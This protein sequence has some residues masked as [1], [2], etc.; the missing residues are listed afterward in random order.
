[1][2]GTRISETVSEPVPAAIP[3]TPP[4]PWSMQRR[5][6][7][8][9]CLL[10]AIPV[11]VA[12]VIGVFFLSQSVTTELEAL[13]HEELEE[14]RSETIALPDPLHGFAAVAKELAGSHPEFPMGWRLHKTSDGKH[15][16]DFGNQALLLPPQ[17]LTPNLPATH[18][19]VVSLGSGLLTATT[20]LTGDLTIT[21][22]LDGSHRIAKIN[23]YWLFGLATIALSVLLSIIAARFLAWRFQSLLDA[24]A[25]RLRK[26]ETRSETITSL[27][28]ELAPIATELETM[29]D[30]VRKRAA[31]AKLFT[32][33]LAHELRSPLQNLIGQAEV[34]MLRARSNEDYQ[35]L[36]QQQVV[37]LHEF[38]RSIDNL[39]YLCSSNEPVHEPPTETFSLGDEVDVR[40]QAERGHAE[41]QQVQL[42]I[43]VHGDTR[44]CADREA[45]I[46]ALRNLINNA[47]KWSQPGQVVRVRIRGNAK[48]LC[49]E[50]HD[51][52]PG[53]PVAE[54]ERVFTPFAQGSVPSGHRA[55]FGLG[56]A[57]IKATAAQHHGSITI[58]DSPSGGA[59]LALVLPRQLSE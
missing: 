3:T 32:A 6:T 51:E 14:A 56:L 55:G 35:E 49:V 12:M 9:F 17:S 22:V 38:A 36:L 58:D 19:E 20:R 34:A 47:V 43:E 2:N 57:M 53:I 45:V 13:V 54:R 41:S 59:L 33:G 15:L 5:I 24:I 27:P 29:L 1:M 10:S 42:D 37:E 8:L 39:L 18:P 46:R 31:E 48:E 50:V 52:G 7:G 40:L 30:N 26:G 25:N 28:N 16:G 11:C 44:V 4:A 21:L 23:N